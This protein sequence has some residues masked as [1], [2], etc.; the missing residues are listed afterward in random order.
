MPPNWSKWG[1]QQGSVLTLHS[2]LVNQDRDQGFFTGSWSLI[3][4]YV[5]YTGENL[6]PLIPNYCT[7]WRFFIKMWIGRQFWKR[8]K[9]TNQVFWDW[10][11]GLE[12]C[13]FLNWH[14]LKYWCFSM[15]SSFH[16][17]CTQTSVNNIILTKLSQ[18]KV[19]FLCI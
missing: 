6:W 8:K 9:Y 2:S 18:K 10:G 5:H 1:G 14:G 19:F 12:S 17:V 7:V 11:Y 4:Y 15:Y 16:L 3:L 13:I